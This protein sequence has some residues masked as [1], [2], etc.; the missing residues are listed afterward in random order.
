MTRVLLDINVV[1]DVLADR[2][3]FAEDRIRHA[4]AAKW[5][6][7]EDAAQAACAEKGG[8][9]VRMSLSRETNETSD[10]RP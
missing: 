6:G 2:Q 1:L 10:G 9:A 5:L 7:F 4:L 8:K 3:P